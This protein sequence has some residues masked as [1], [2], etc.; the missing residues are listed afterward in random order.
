MPTRPEAT[1]PLPTPWADF[2]RATVRLVFPLASLAV[3]AGL[4]YS[5]QGRDE[6]RALV[7]AAARTDAGNIIGG[8]VFLM[9]G[10]SVLSASVWYASRWLFTGQMA[11]LPLAPTGPWQTWLPRVLGFSA[12]FMVAL[13]LFGLNHGSLPLEGDEATTA[14]WW[15]LWFTLLAA[16]L[17]VFYIVRGALIVRLHRRLGGEASSARRID[18]A[19]HSV[20]EKIGLREATPAV[21][22][23]VIVW[24]IAL[25]MA[26]GALFVLFPITLPRTMGAAAVAA[27][28]LASINLFGSFVLTYFPLRRALPPMWLWAVLL[29]G[30]VVARFNDNHVVQPAP[31]EMPAVQPAVLPAAP[32]TTNLLQEI[33]GSIPEDGVIV[34]V[35]SEGG[36]IRAAY[37]TAAVLAA[38][39]AL[40][41]QLKFRMRVLSGVSGGSL[42]LTAWLATQRGDFCPTS[43]ATRAASASTVGL[44]SAAPPTLP[45]TKALAADFVSP[46][47]AGMFYGDL[48]Q[49]F[50]P[51]P[52]GA[53]DRSR[54]IEG[55]W[56]RAF[57]HLPGQPLE[58]TLDAFYAGCPKLPHLVLNATRVETGERVTLTRLPTDAATFVNTFDAMQ[59]GSM[60]PRQSVAGLVHHSARFP[61][62]SPAS[63]VTIDGASG[64][65]PPSFRLVDGGYFDNSGVQSALDVMLTLRRLPRTTPLRPLLLVIRNTDE[66]LISQTPHP[67]GASKLFPE[68]GSVVSALLNV[69]ASH[70]VTARSIA[71]RLLG[72]DLIDLGVPR[73]YAEA[74]LGWALSG[75]AQRKLDEGARNVAEKAM[76]LIAQRIAAAASAAS[77]GSTAAGNKP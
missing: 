75:A 19:G 73:Q 58:H 16:A 4:L 49:R 76:P 39:D 27:M 24:S 77:A 63:T 62:L 17:L 36:G 37:W 14:R 3:L 34:F 46:A 68:S 21:T 6:L 54:A 29:A 5:A 48:M 60:A 65:V 11:G 70:A 45:A 28:A 74:P 9:A 64:D 13:G 43:H 47:V 20:P 7:S 1:R 25:T 69:R 41:P 52:F 18:A 35:A 42:G 10:S 38:L 44:F 31:S 66:P 30:L 72:D 40:D 61:L 22:R 51:Y 53:L 59:S 15:A 33:A 67:A 26:L 2:V 23:L 57:A 56:Q 55:A 12:P 71:K 32:S 8:L 50:I